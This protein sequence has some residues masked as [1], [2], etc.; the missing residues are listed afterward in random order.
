MIFNFSDGNTKRDVIGGRH[1]LQY[2][3]G[4]RPVS[5]TLTYRQLNLLANSP[6]DYKNMMLALDPRPQSDDL[7]GS[8]T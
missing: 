7:T 2:P 3:N 1:R 4:E 8:E 5:V 6:K